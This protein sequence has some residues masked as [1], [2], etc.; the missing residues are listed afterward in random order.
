MEFEAASFAHLMQNASVLS[1]MS[2]TLC[3]C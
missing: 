1:Q 2:D 3:A